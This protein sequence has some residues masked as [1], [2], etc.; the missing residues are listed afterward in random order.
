MSEYYVMVGSREVEG[1]FDDRK[2]AKRRAD[3]LNTNEVGTN[4]TVRKQR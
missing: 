4:Y 3:E 1:P 2:Q